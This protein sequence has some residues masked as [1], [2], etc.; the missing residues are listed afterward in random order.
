MATQRTKCIPATPV[1]DKTDEY[2][3]NNLHLV[4]GVTEIT[5]E[6][7][8]RCVFYHHVT[9]DHGVEWLDVWSIK[10]DQWRACSIDRV[11]RVHL[12]VTRKRE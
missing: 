11:K 12:G 1:F 9:N 2:K 8:G 6:G 5:V 4:S 3:I 7:L 10:L